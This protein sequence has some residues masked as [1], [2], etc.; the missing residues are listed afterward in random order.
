[1]AI[2]I[3][4]DAVSRK[5]GA[6]CALDKVSLD[7][8]AGEFFTLLGSSGSGKSS[9]LKL[10]GGFDKPDTGRILFDGSDV[11]GVA[12]NKRP[13]NTV[14]QSLALFP[15]MDVA[16]NVGYGL[17]LRKVDPAQQKRRVNE[18][19]ELVNLGGF[20]VRDVNLLSGGQRQRVALA[21]ALVM[22][23]GVLLLDEPLTGLDERLRQQMRDEFG[24]LHRRTGATFILVTHNQ[25]EALSLSGRMGIMHKGRLEQ[26]APPAAFFVAPASPFV[27]RFLGMETFLN[28][29]QVIA[30]G[31]HSMAIV[32]GQAIPI[33]AGKGMSSET[34]LLALRIERR[35]LCSTSTP[36][37]LLL[38]VEE[39]QVRVLKVQLSLGFPDGQRFSMP[40]DPDDY[41]S[42]WTM[43]QAIG[44][45]LKKDAAL[46]VPKLGPAGQASA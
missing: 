23:P 10:I 37:A 12:A 4:I 3:N 41:G 6:V 25:D 22:E 45:E 19:L 26:V 38:K 43:G 36:N 29:T 11:T 21:R 14:F 1:M 34:S 18:A 13:V 39:V 35:S 2:S 33:R 28:T 31:E 42:P 20:G 40:V 24:R 27:A 15:H 8:Q 44:L 16:Q 32:A 46:L 7:I 30:N 5:Y 17:R 9:L